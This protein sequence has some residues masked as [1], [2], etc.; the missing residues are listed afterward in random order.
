MLDLVPDDIFSQLPERYQIRA[1][2]IAA[3][4]ADIDRITVPCD[5]TV[6]RD[7][8]IRLRGQLR[9][10]PDV[11]ASEFA[12]E[13]KLA[14]AD[15]PEWAV[16]E[17]TNDFLAGRVEH[18]TG[19][20][21]PTCAEFA[22]HARAIVAPFMGERAALRTEASRLL[23]RAADDRRREVIANERMAPDFHERLSR[24]KAQVLQ[25]AGRQQTLPP[26][27]GIDVDMQR[28]ID[29]LKIS[30]PE[31]ASKLHM[32]KAGRSK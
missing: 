16:S 8:A 31:P 12:A 19:Q 7:A 4:V 30:R 1:R 27:S 25:G 21:M 26:H 20:F 28:K 10:Q 11:E 2:Q 23:E 9:P 15:L 22:K 6:L 24:L 32:T 17:A 3:R 13:F 5:V 14:C 29:A 18:H